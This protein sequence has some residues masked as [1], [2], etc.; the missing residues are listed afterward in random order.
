MTGLN[1]STF[2]ELLAIFSPIFHEYTPHVDSGCNISQ[3]PYRHIH[4]GRRQTIDAIIALSLVLVWTQTRGTYASLQ[5]IFGMT[6]SNISKWLWFNKRILLLALM[7]VKEAKIQMP[8]LQQV[9][10]FQEVIQA[11]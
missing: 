11:R 8:S 9:R 6:A 10:F 5:V 4:R 3:L 7:G 2:H 1:Y